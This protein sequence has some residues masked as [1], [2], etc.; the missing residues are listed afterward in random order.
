MADNIEEDKGAAANISTMSVTETPK[1]HET[2]SESPKKPVSFTFSIWPPTEKTRDAVINRLTETISAPSILSKRY[3][4]IP[5]E[6]ASEIAKRIEEEAFNAAAE[7]AGSVD[8]DDGLEVLQ[9]YSK[10]VSKRML[11]TVKS[12]SATSP[13]PESKPSEIDEKS[14]APPA[15]SDEIPV[16]EAES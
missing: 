4:V 10:E 14:D 9:V 11:D 6:E 7:S 3:G 16:A 2:S 15:N 8:G 13:V 12:R 5:Q 1:A